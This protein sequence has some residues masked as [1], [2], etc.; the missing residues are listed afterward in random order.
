MWVDQ[1]PIDADPDWH[2]NGNL[3]QD[4][5]RHQNDVDPQHCS[6]LKFFSPD[7]ITTIKYNKISVKTT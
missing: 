1:H 2:Q 7:T 3:D 4:P 5:D 6:I